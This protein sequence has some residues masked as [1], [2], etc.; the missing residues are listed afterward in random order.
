MTYYDTVNQVIGL[1]NL[2]YDLSI[3]EALLNTADW[4]M[5]DNLVSILADTVKKDLT[6]ELSGLPQLIELAIAQGKSGNKVKLTVDSLAITSHASLITVHDI[7]WVLRARGRA[8]LALKKKI[9]EK[10]KP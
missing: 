3:E 6:E 10:K 9:L 4:M 7:Q 2:R 1:S 5:H 8:G